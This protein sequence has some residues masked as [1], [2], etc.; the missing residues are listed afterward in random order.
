MMRE[1]WFIFIYKTLKNVLPKNGKLMY[2]CV[3]S[4]KNESFV[5]LRY[6]NINARFY[7]LN[8]P[9]DANSEYTWYYKVF[10]VGNYIK[11]ATRCRGRV[12]SA[13]S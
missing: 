7:F 6:Y 4:V 3:G 1:T 10:T 11:L 13:T 9:L 5:W 8:S 12:I 2:P